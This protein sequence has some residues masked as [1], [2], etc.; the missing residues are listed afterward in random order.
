MPILIWH[1][2]EDEMFPMVAAK[3]IYYKYAFLCGFKDNVILKF[4]ENHTHKV[5][6]EGL[7]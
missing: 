4:E 6:L 2:A 5:S 1:G 3:H 7:N